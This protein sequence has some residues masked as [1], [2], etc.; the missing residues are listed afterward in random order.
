MNYTELTTQVA[1][2]CENTFTA[3]QMSTFTRQAEEK[4]Y[5]TV[6]FPDLRKNQT[7]TLTLDNEYLSVPTDFLASYSLAVSVSGSY[8]FLIPKDVNFI[9]EAYPSRTATGVPKHYAYFSEDSFILG[10][11]PD[12]AYT[13]ELHYFYRPESIVTA[14][15]TW[16]GDNFE[17]ALLNGVLLEAFRFLRAEE[18]TMNDY[19]ESYMQAMTN[20]KNLADGKQRQDS[21]RFGQVAQQV[22]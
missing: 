19:K 15:T 13:V 18:D 20:L 4:I 1:D 9:R 6:Q 8:Q 12:S 16:L 21:Y 3:D 10:P 2:I 17:T 7:G 14:A 5:N 22:T 11:T